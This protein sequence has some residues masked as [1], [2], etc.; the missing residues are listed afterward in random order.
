MDLKQFI[1]AT[2][3]QATSDMA[4]KDDIAVLGRK[5]DD[6]DLKMDTIAEALQ[7]QLNDH[8]TRISRLEQPVPHA[9]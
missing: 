2:V 5:I 1:F 3:T 4:T 8:E 7:E 9:A 6:L